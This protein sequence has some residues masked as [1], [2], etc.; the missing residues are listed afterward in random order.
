[1]DHEK[2]K[3]RITDLAADDCP[4]E[5]L[6]KLGP[7]ALSNS[8]LIAI[9]LR[10]GVQGEN[11]AQ[12][13]QRLLQKFGGIRGLHRASLTEVKSQHGIGAAKAATIKAAI[14]L[15]QWLTIESPEE[16]PTIHSPADAAALVQ[17]VTGFSANN[18]LKKLW[19]KNK[20]Y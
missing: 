17:F 8:E 9:L 1:V 2:I 19:M 5:R 10:V 6:V 3:Y 4:H 16:R 14:E 15:G 20:V 13:G 12:V 18:W 11:A 7:Q